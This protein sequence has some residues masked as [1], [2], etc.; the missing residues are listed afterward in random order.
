MIFYII[1]CYD[2]EKKA[3]S[4]MLVKATG[5]ELHLY[6]CGE[7]DQLENMLM[8]RPKKQC[9]CRWSKNIFN[10]EHDILDILYTFHFELSRMA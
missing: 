10:V 3:A 1:T 8:I 7:K 5:N 4:L 2:R 6:E 9:K